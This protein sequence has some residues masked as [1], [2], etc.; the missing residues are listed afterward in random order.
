MVYFQTKNPSLGK[1]GRA[2]DWKNLMYF[3]DIWDILRTFGIFHDHLLHFVF[4]WCIV[5]SFGIM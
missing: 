4:T 5:S 3:M 1:F 2:F